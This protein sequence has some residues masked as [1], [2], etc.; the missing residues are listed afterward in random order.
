MIRKKYNKEFKVAA[1]KL[2]LQESNTITKVTK[3]LGIIPCMLSRWVYEYE[4]YGE[5]VFPGNAGNGKPS[6]N[7][8]FE[9]KK[10]QKK[11]KN[12]IKRKNVF[13]CAS[14]SG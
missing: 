6:L 10:L 5:D 8:D 2:A 11:V 12:Y 14:I 3:D 13:T 4:T 9:I 7:K 1:V